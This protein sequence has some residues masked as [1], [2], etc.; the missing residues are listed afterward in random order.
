MSLEH[1]DQSFD[2]WFVVETD[3]LFYSSA[4]PWGGPKST[5][6]HVCAC[7]PELLEQLARAQRTQRIVIHAALVSAVLHEGRLHGKQHRLVCVCVGAVMAVWICHVLGLSWR[8]GE[9]I[10]D[11]SRYIQAMQAILHN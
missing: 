11:E 1:I 9:M 2:V 3:D 4:L 7:I 10:F 6:T 5:R 8:S